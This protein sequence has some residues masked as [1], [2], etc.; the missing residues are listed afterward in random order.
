MSSLYSSK[1]IPCIAFLLEMGAQ[2]QRI[3]KSE[4]KWTFIVYSDSI[5]LDSLA[6]K[7]F[8][9]SEFMLCP[10]AFNQRVHDLFSMAKSKPVTSYL[11]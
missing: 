2:I 6:R 3:D 1:E 9:G 11:G 4:Q 5:D 7:Y 8:M 10:K